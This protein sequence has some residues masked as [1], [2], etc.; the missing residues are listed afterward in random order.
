MRL[1]LRA[2]K[3]IGCLVATHA[4]VHTAHRFMLLKGSPWSLSE[5]GVELEDA[6]SAEN[7]TVCLVACLAR[8]QY[9]LQISINMDKK[10]RVYF[11]IKDKENREVRLP[12]FTGVGLGDKNSLY[13]YQ[14]TI[15]R[16]QKSFFHSRYIK[17]CV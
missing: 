16:N 14:P 2:V 10:T 6:I 3:K 4:L 12:T 11:F 7:L 15:T 1:R 5:E 8:A 13:V 17:R 9:K